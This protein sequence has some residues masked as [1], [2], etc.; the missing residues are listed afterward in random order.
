MT[1]SQ[2][3]YSFTTYAASPLYKND[4]T[5]LKI[6]LWIDIV[7]IDSV[8]Y[9]DD[10]EVSTIGFD[11]EVVTTPSPAGS[12]IQYRH[13]QIIGLKNSKYMLIYNKKVS[14]I[15][16]RVKFVIKTSKSFFDNL[17]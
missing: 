12:V 11:Y 16:M 7:N 14:N 1:L 3:G 4:N 10:N 9:F 8:D 13:K 5:I 15:S 17:I 2:I 6:L